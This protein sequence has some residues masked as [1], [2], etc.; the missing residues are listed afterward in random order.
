MAK[1]LWLSE[2]LFMPTGFGG[3]TRLVC[4]GLAAKG[5]E[6]TVACGPGPR[7]DGTLPPNLREWR[8]ANLGDLALIERLAEQLRPDVVVVF[9]CMS[10]NAQMMRLP[11]VPANAEMTLWLPWE[12]TSLPEKGREMFSCVPPNRA[13]NLSQFARRLWRDVCPSDIVIPHGVELDEF[14]FYDPE[15]STAQARRRALRRKWSKRLRCYL[16]SDAFVLI[17]V[18]R[19][20]YH[21]LWDATFDMVRRVTELLPDREVQLIAH[22]RKGKH[23][24]EEDKKRGDMAYNLPKMERYYGLKPGQVCYTNFDWDRGVE[25]NELRE[26]F[27]LSDVRISTSQGEGF[28]IPTLECMATGCPQVVPR[29]TC[30]PEVLGEDSRWLVDPAFLSTRQ[31]GMFQMPNVEDMAQRAAWIEGNPEAVAEL[32][33][34][35]RQRV[36][37]RFAAPVVVDQWDAWIRKLAGNDKEGL[38]YTYRRGWGYKSENL[39]QLRACAEVV[40]QIAGRRPVLEVGSFDGAFLE[41]A[42]ERNV[43]I[44]GLEPDHK[45]LERCTGRAREFLADTDFT[46]AE[47]PPAYVVVLTDIWCLV[48]ATGG[49]ADIQGVL[50]QVCRYQWAVLRFGG[51]ARWGY[52]FD[53]VAEC[54]EFLQA[55]GMTRRHDL[56][57]AGKELDS[58]FTHEVW[59]HGT[60]TSKV[61]EGLLG[62]AK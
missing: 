29:T 47:W 36:E 46:M 23:A 49:M 32:L 58:N 9:W 41:L 12:G 30:L 25:R 8:F 24:T 27:G 14:G 28:G 22:T 17:N 39:A 5:H 61:P 16:D 59:M 44:A 3:Q 51:A 40:G 33:H 57:R 13:V 52:N 55:G 6:V 11:T 18:D 15:P 4:E 53:H 62:G 54:A 19:N 38:W 42:L 20:T 43:A 10:V 1:V 60:D 26:L 2:S 56:E 50:E 21:K 48:N 45:A 31:N 34:K 35:D 37:E 7:F